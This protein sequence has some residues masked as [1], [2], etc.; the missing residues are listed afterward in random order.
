M[1]RPV[2]FW[3]ALFVAT[4]LPAGFPSRSGTSPTTGTPVAA[5][6]AAHDLCNSGRKALTENRLGDASEAFEKALASWPNIAEAHVGLGHVSMRR[7]MFE[8][9]LSEYRA[10]RTAYVAGIAEAIDSANRRFVDAQLGIEQRRQEIED[11]RNPIHGISQS[12]VDSRTRALEREIAQLEKID[13]PTASP[14]A[15]VPAEFD[16]FIGN[17]LFRLGRTA[18]AAAAWESCAQS[19]P[20]Y[21]PVYINL[22][23]AYF[24]LGRKDDARAAAATSGQL[25]IPVPAEFKT[26]LGL[27]P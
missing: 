16:F 8:N 25:G 26:R 13:R 14:R 15:P 6:R 4:L 7:Q 21:A 11:M 22:A 9:A 24:Q 19:D 1:T 12:F 23:V 18:E 2:L 20:R 27:A 17:A 3:C 10:A 5:Q